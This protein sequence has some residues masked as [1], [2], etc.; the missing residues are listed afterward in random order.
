[1][2]E[3]AKNA[4]QILVYQW[5][6]KD[7]PSK[8]S[9][10]TEMVEFLNLKV[11]RFGLKN[12]GY[13]GPHPMLYCVATN[14]HKLGF[15]VLRISVKT[16]LR[17]DCVEYMNPHQ[18]ES[19]I[20]LFTK[21]FDQDFD[22]DVT[23]VFGIHIV[24]TTEHYGYQLGDVLLKE[25]LWL[26]ARH[27]QF[28]DVE[29]AVKNHLYWAHQVIVAA[30]S[31]VLAAVLT[32]KEFR[33]GTERVIRIKIED[34]DPYVFEDFLRFLYTG[35]FNVNADCN[36]LMRVADR[37]QVVTL[38][39]LCQ[40][41]SQEISAAQLTSFAIA[42]KPDFESSTKK[43]KTELRGNAKSFFSFQKYFFVLEL[44]WRL[45]ELP[46]S[47]L[48]ATS[49]LS[50]FEKQGVFRAGLLHNALKPNASLLCPEYILYLAA[51]E[52]QRT[53]IELDDAESFING[54]DQSPMDHRGEKSLQVFGQELYA[55]SAPVTFQFNVKV[56]ETVDN[57]RYQLQDTYWPIQLWSAYQ[58][59]LLT[60]VEILVDDRVLHAHR[61]VLGARS[62]VM[63]TIFNNCTSIESL[64]GK[65]QIDD[66][67]G[68]TFE[69]FLYFLYTGTPSLS[70]NNC[71]LLKLAEKYQVATLSH[72]CQ[73]A[74]KSLD[75]D[76][77][78]TS[79]I[80]F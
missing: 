13:T 50:Q 72:L 29:F 14:L 75:V 1:M 35:E 73:L 16:K 69:E 20:Q 30:R 54:C 11:F 34:T 62:V 44:T 24:E 21:Q 51:T 65:L 61:A 37:Y 57:Y 59:R 47:G 40:S 58:D 45:E 18:Q 38:K 56:H 6:L 33:T 70:L 3:T 49:D 36:Q 19:C 53:G 41:L 80:W 46:N 4:G 27:K 74:T 12:E 77:I 78:S 48:L 15:Q 67:D 52:T 63:A 5:K 8:M 55:L 32:S 28:T 66:V 39:L 23:I 71:E 60:D 7:L 76:E 43:P 25:Q 68:D 22:E 2:T 42:M 64:T 9:V 17:S 26:A 31:P 79:L 10:M